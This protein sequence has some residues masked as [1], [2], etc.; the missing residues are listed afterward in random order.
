MA[1]S[2]QAPVIV[3]FRDDLRLADNPALTEA[4][5]SGA[6]VVPLYILDEESEGLRPL[7]GAVKWWLHKSLE[8]IETS[9]E[10]AGSK[11]VL[12]RGKAAHVIRDLAETLRPEAV[13]WNRRYRAAEVEIDKAIK[14]ALKGKGIRCE[15]FNGHLLYEPWTV[16]GKT[17]GPMRVFTPFWRA[18][19][20]LG[21]PGDMLAPITM[22]PASS[23]TIESDALKDWA[24]LPE[25]PDWSDGI[26]EEWT[27]GED[28]AAERVEA[29]LSGPVRGYK[30]KRNRPDT[31]STSKLSPHLRFG[32]ISPRQIWHESVRYARS[33]GASDSVAKFQSELGWREFSYHLLFHNPGL[34]SANY[35]KKF[36]GFPWRE[37]HESL[38]AWQEGRTGYP[39]VDAGMRELWRTGWMHN[40]VRM[41]AGSFLIKDLMID[42]REGEAWFWDTLVDADMANNPASWQW[43]AGSG[44]DA[45]PYFRV[46]NPVLQGEKFDPNGVY[47]RKWVQEL[48]Y[49]PDKYIHKPWEAPIT[50]LSEAGITLGETYPAPIIDHSEARDRALKAFKALSG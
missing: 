6:P 45:A 33:N 43:V 15:T 8:S 16:N 42:W 22:L 40:R 38:K 11:L 24:L 21:E 10:E 3:W 41:V 26:A 31:E 9:L 34:D 1:K 29:F 12:R 4:A 32:E 20:A 30:D 44:A 28:G 47:V 14:S 49:L 37:D 48:K 39:I 18:A 36:N 35:Q 23:A 27:P 17:G 25:K 7:G 5:N 13:F 46:F 2:A 19:R 50:V